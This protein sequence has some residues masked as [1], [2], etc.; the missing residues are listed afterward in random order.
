[1]R[2]LLAILAIALAACAHDVRAR[3]PSPA[4]TPPGETGSVTL[5]LTRPASDVYVAIDG[6]L[7]VDGADTSHVVID[8]LPGGYADMTVAIGDGEKAMQVWVEPGR[9]TVVPV[10]A[11]AASATDS[12][13]NMVLSIAAVALYAWIRTL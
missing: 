4:G 11:P 12:I 13:K 9:T 5:V 7:V 10:P 8:G 2:W 1:M 3:F 6:Q